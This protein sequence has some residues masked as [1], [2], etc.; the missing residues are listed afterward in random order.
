ME[1][2]GSQV[3]TGDIELKNVVYVFLLLP[4]EPDVRRYKGRRKTSS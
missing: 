3:E 1:N 2:K 4:D